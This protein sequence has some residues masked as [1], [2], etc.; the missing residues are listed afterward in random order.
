MIGGEGVAHGVVELCRHPSLVAGGVTLSDQPLL[1]GLR[2][3]AGRPRAP[4]HPGVSGEIEATASTR[5]RTMK[6]GL[7]ALTCGHL[8]SAVGTRVHSAQMPSR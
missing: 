7:N 6:S 3:R 1:G 2:R 5:T 4:G 8:A